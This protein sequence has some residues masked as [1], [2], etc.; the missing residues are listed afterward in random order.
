MKCISIRFFFAFVFCIESLQAAS[1]AKENYERAVAAEYQR[2]IAAAQNGD[3]EAQ[4]NLGK[5][6]AR[7]I[8]T[9]KNIDEAAKWLRKA[10]DQNYPPAQF[11]LADW[12]FD[13]VKVPKDQK[14]SVRLYTVVAERGGRTA[15]LRLSKCYAQGLGV[16]AD[17]LLAC[18]WAN[19]V[20]YSFRNYDTEFQQAVVI[21]QGAS[22]SLTQKEIDKANDLGAR[23]YDEI[24][25][26][27]RAES[28]KKTKN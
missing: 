21:L 7:G 20:K 15:S 16:K 5:V 4:Y 12:L 13:G 11:T 26:K 18:A 14:E 22:K 3:A 19:V 1:N 27:V 9:T 6:Y 8:G 28:Q 23:M 17:P 24:Q 25:K 2:L 10:A